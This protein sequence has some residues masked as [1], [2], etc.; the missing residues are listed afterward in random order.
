MDQD[1]ILNSDFLSL[2]RLTVCAASGSEKENAIGFQNWTANE[3]GLRE[4]S[5]VGRGEK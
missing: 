3:T 2:S 1:S 4:T 5:Q